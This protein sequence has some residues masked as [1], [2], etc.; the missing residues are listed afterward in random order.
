MHGWEIWA[1]LSK[2]RSCSWPIAA[3]CHGIS[4]PLS[5]WGWASDRSSLRDWRLAGLLGALGIF[6]TYLIL[7]VSNLCSQNLEVT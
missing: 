2:V 6:C 1:T 7:C 3:G 5:Q 4:S